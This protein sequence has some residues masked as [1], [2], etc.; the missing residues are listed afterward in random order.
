MS[1]PSQRNITADD[2]RR[3][4]ETDAHG[5]SPIYE[6]LAVAISED[7]RVTT[8]MQLV[9]ARQRKPALLFSVLRLHGVPADRPEVAIEWIVDHPQLLLSELRDRRI[10]TNEA[11]RA[12]ALMPAVA[13][14]AGGREIALIELGAS[15]GL[16]LLLD[17][18]R[19]RYSAATGEQRVGDPDSSVTLTC[20]V[21]GNVPIPAQVPSVGRRIGVDVNPLSPR[22]RAHR[23]WLESFVWPQHTEGLER[24]VAALD[25]AA[26]DPPKIIRA[27]MVAGL[28]TLL[29]R[30]P[31]GLA[32]VVMHAAA[33]PYISDEKQA[34]VIE[35]CRN[36]GV[37]RVGLEADHLDDPTLTLTIDTGPPIRV[38]TV[39]PH[40]EWIEGTG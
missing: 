29:E 31:D 23:K 13:S 25:M 26:L 1:T 17:K 2:F 4:A 38:A 36:A 10:Q 3:W 34:E 40:G 16:L 5:R 21:R 32:P 27:D 15:A 9:S 33:F 12:T 20:A 8:L 28:K 14:V 22:D 7:E 6:R 39:Q 18:Y 24:L 35:L 11:R 19:Y 30:V 37:P